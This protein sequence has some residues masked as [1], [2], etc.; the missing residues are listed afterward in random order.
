MSESD[1]SPA[2]IAGVG[3][4]AGGLEAIEAFFSAMPA[5]SEL[6]FVV[7]QHLSPDYKSLM[8]EI[9]SKRTRM[10]VHRAEEG[11]SIRAG[12][13]YL[14]PPRTN[15][16]IFHGKLLLHEQEPSRGVN[17]P[18]DVFLRSL[19]ED[20]GERAIAVIL[21]GTGSD[22]M[23][24]V[25]AVKQADGMIMVQDPAGAKSDGMP[26]AAISTG[27]ADFVLPAGEMADRLV[28]FTRHPH[29]VS[30]T[31]RER[32]HVDEDGMTRIFA[33]LRERCK[34]D[35]THYKPSTVTRR[36][37]RRMAITGVETTDEYANHLQSNPAEVTTLFRELL[38]GVTSFF[39]DT[40]VFEKLRAEVIPGLVDAA[41]GRELR[42][43]VVGC[44][45]GE[46]AYTLAMLIRDA[47]D[48]RG[49]AL[50]VRIFATDIDR[51][52]LQFAATGSYPESVAA[53]I[54]T[55][56][57]SRYFV[58]KD[59][60]FQV[61]RSVR[62]MV[63]FAQHNLV[64]DPPFTSIDLISCRNLLIYLQPVLQTKVLEFFLFSLR[65]DGV[66]LL[67]TSETVGE[68]A[69]G[70]RTVDHTTKIFRSKGRLR[71]VSGT[72]E[73]GHSSGDSGGGPGETRF[74]EISRQARALRA[75]TRSDG[76][77]TLE[78]FLETVSSRFLPTAVIVNENLEVLHVVGDSRPYMQVP[79]GRPTVELERIVVKE[80][81]IPFVTGLQ[82]VFREQKPLEFHGVRVRDGETTRVVDLI[83]MPIEERRGQ[84]PLAAGLVREHEAEGD[85]ECIDT[86]TYDLS[87]EA[88]QRITD[89]EQEL[90][91]SR[92]NLQATIEELETANEELQATNEELLASNEELQSTNEELQSTNEELFTVNAEY[93]AKIVELNELTGDVENLLASSTIGL[94]LLDEN[95]TVRRFSPGMTRLLD[96]TESDV[97]RAIERVP[98]HAKEFDLREAYRDAEAGPG[99]WEVET[100]EGAWFLLHAE[101][102]EIGP[103]E[104][105]GTVISAV[106]ITDRK[107][108]E[109]ELAERHRR[110]EEDEERYRLLVENAHAI[111][112]EY[113]IPDDEWTYVAPQVTGILG[114]APKEWV[115]YAFWLDRLHPDDRGWASEYCNACTARG[116]THV[117]EYR[118]RAKDDSYRWLRDVVTVELADGKPVRIRG[119]MIDITDRKDAEQHAEQLAAQRELLLR[120]MSHRVKNNLA[121]LGSLLELQAGEADQP[122]VTDALGDARRRIETVQAIYELLHRRSPGESADAGAYVSDIARHVVDAMGASDT[123]RTEVDVRVVPVAADALLPLGILVNELITN[124]MKHAFSGGRTGTIRVSLADGDGSTATLSISDDG[125]G[126]D[127]QS[128][129]GGGLGLTLV[130]GLA[131]QLGGRARIDSGPAGTVATIAFPREA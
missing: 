117:F 13:I 103:D 6:G 118:F 123:V 95:S 40:E 122:A 4:S 43:W 7:V 111:P 58:R 113:S 129:P 23:R 92:E 15:L 1:S 97:G 116:E 89:L 71:L 49:D 121:T 30:E 19:A 61:T 69:D 29:L 38:I 99:D 115:D 78:R 42:L 108:I 81:A 62:E 32:L 18:I 104:T 76:E 46:E 27:L 17:L 24:G 77:R 36:V 112:W 63:V 74:G 80:L 5:E 68:M 102:Y 2:F 125:T 86:T 51:D 72:S 8:V 67:G 56:F 44:S 39:R 21:S 26:R 124:S 53:D 127:P 59:D 12:A 55:E 35:F 87:H 60:H 14:I 120:E 84:A 66:L 101:P 70:L 93:N 119:Y 100:V 79:A 33:M 85:D 75:A 57:L 31:N 28:A 48:G 22:G 10:P 110:L 107:R 73:G 91:F 47:L 11:M 54:P 34:V 88:E 65:P 9:L 20:Q 50:D 94:L 128:A 90:H 105:S 45:T 98:S 25:R 109:A 96:L 126:F 41:S 114:Y 83:L 82:K 130:E 106:D 37:D 64:K 3:A 131:E 16:T 52:A